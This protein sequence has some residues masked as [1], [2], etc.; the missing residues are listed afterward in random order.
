MCIRTGAPEKAPL[1]LLRGGHMH[2]NLKR[3][4]PAV[5]VVLAAC[6]VSGCGGGCG[7]GDETASLSG[8][9]LDAMSGNGLNQAYVAVDTTS[10]YAESDGGFLFDGLAP[11]TVH[12]EAGTDGYY[13]YETDIELE[14]G[15]EVERD[16]RLVPESNT[17]E[18][19]F[20]VWSEH[21]A[22]LDAHLWVPV[23]LREGY[24]IYAGDPGSLVTEPYAA[25]ALNDTSGYGPEIV[26]IRQNNPGGWPV[27]YHDGE[28]VF[29]VRHNGGDSGIPESG[30]YV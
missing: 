28:F 12:V 14:D 18:Y 2:K 10:L 21:P 29:A 6:A 3:L 23:G 20:I 5:V 11:G 19:R 9:V 30:A 27:T 7:C 26:T 22:G 4:L 16:F 15:D 17:W 13:T 1:F 25:L 8:R 24:H